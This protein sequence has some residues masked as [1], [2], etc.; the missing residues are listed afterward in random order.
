[1]KQIA[2]LLLTVIALNARSSAPTIPSES[3]NAFLQGCDGASSDSDSGLSPMRKGFCVGY[4]Q[5]VVNGYDLAQTTYKLRD[6]CEPANAQNGQVFEVVTNFVK[7][8]PEVRHWQTRELVARA[9]IEAFPCPAAT[10]K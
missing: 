2:I 9:M 4:I 3:G 8:H 6:F 10:K 7:G 5:G 1:M